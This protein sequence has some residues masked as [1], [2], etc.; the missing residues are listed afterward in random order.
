MI[1]KSPLLPVTSCCRHH[2]RR[3]RSHTDCCSSHNQ[4]VNA[5]GEL[6]GNL[7][8]SDLRGI[9]QPHLAAL[10]LP[11]GDFLRLVHGLAQPPAAATAPRS[12]QWFLNDTVADRQRKKRRA[13]PPPGPSSCRA[14][15]VLR[16]R[17]DA[18]LLRQQ[19]PLRKDAD[20]RACSSCLR[21]CC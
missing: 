11:V 13:L 19:Q 4:Q 14:P 1:T 3:R 8:V 7:S 2:R 18:L 21:F 5:A 10:A 15:T 16:C 17:L 9:V 20:C 12:Y 6:V